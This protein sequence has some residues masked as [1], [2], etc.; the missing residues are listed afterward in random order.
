MTERIQINNST[1][2]FSDLPFTN[3]KDVLEFSVYLQELYQIIRNFISL[4]INENTKVKITI[5]FVGGIL[6]RIGESL[7]STSYLS[8]K[9]FN[10][11]VAIILVNLIEL[12]TDLK[13]VSEN[14]NEASNWLSHKERNHKPWRFSKQI[15]ALKSDE[16]KRA[17]KKIYELCSMAKHGNPVGIDVGFNIGVCEEGIFYG[18]QNTNRITDYLH[19]AYYYAVDAVEAGLKILESYELKFPTVQNEIN[20]LTKKVNLLNS[21]CLKR[22]IIE[23]AYQM[24]PEIK[25]IDE[26]IKRLTEEKEAVDRKIKALRQNINEIK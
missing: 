20:D 24:H 12:R 8:V 26:E 2:Q 22:K 9:G 6:D 5:G 7:M 15:E 25:Q 21:K 17:D 1:Y 3:N 18:G 10:R 19:W 13:Y 16:M 23:Y 4:I 11:D 14:P